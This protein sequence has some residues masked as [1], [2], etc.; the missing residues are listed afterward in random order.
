MV[1][2]ISTSP[3]SSKIGL[4]LWHAT[5][6]AVGVFKKSLIMFQ[7][8]LVEFVPTYKEKVLLNQLPKKT[9][10]K[11]CHLSDNCLHTLASFMSYI[12]CFVQWVMVFKPTDPT[13][14]SSSQITTIIHWP[15]YCT[16]RVYVVVHFYDSEK[17]FWVKVNLCR[18]FTVC[19][20]LYCYW[21]SNYQ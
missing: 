8:G 15:C 21:R 11:V 7:N 6:S 4:G 3:V 18:F 17:S 10:Q 5:C 14:L 1:Y 12:I 16:V 13:F 2:N 20:Y 19:L 9:G